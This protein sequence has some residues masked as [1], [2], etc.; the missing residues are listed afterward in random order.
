[1]GQ[2]RP[3]GASAG[4]DRLLHV[5]DVRDR[6]Y[7][8]AWKFDRASLGYLG[9]QILCPAPIDRPDWR[10]RL[11]TVAV[12]A[13]QVLALRDYARF[14]MRMLGDEPQIL[15]VNVNPDLLADGHSAFVLAAQAAGIGY[16]QMVARILELAA[17]RMPL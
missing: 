12:R 16:A 7:T 8:E 13:Y 17:V 10:A 14:D 11:E 6:L 9:V 15:D 5:P 1:M 3:G 4:R 2:R